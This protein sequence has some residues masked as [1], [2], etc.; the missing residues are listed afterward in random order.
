M[1][2]P[3]L[4]WEGRGAHSALIKMM[5]LHETAI[6]HSKITIKAPP[7]TLRTEDRYNRGGGRQR[8]L[9]CQMESGTAEDVLCCVDVQVHE[10]L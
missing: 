9:C 6:I 7:V 5:Y 3:V 4:Q 1:W 8:Q 2:E 10:V